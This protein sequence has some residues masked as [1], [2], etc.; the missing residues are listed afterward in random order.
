MSNGELKTGLWERSGRL[1][2]MASRVAGQELRHG[3]R[4]RL[5]A[6]AEARLRDEVT[7]RVAQAR[8]LT[9]SLGELKGAAMK[10]GQLLSIDAG[11]LLPDE[12]SAVLAKL[13]RHADPVPFQVIADVLLDE[14]G[15]ARLARL[16][17][18]ETIPAAAA[19]IGQV[20][21]ARVEGRPVAV[22]VQYP[23]IADTIDSDMRLLEKLADSWLVLTRSRIEIEETFEEMRSILHLEAD[24]EAEL[25]HL[26][27]FHA[28]L[29]DDD[30]FVVPTPYPE[31]STARVLTMSW[32]EG[33]PLG[34]WIAR[35]PG[36]DQRHRLA[37]SVLEL[38]CSEFFRWGLVQTDP[39]HGNF[40][41]RDD[42]RIVLLDFGATLSYDEGF[43]ETYVA[44]LRRLARGDV[45]RTIDTGIAFGIL[46]PR[47]PE[48][49]RQLFAEMLFSA[50]EPFRADLQPF[51]FRD[52]VYAAR[53]RDV[54]IRFTRS[55]RYS[56]PPRKLLFLH[57]K[58][59][60]IFQL[61]RRL[62]VTLDL[63]PYWGRM[64]GI[65][66]SSQAA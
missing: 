51:R 63:R 62:D 11:D 20:H 18:L 34:D 48:E 43:R 28:H 65:S 41:V 49:A 40:L 35:G 55:L 5:A 24:Y 19:S 53:S 16:E 59:G 13:Q 12:A 10:A 7:T 60:G 23:G 66:P 54:A 37:S 30:R 22:K 26:Q 1:L 3:L 38:Y 27:A 44:L 6:T 45:E 47:E 31:L 9:Q 46:D 36:P 39:N 14:L 4:K 2:G 32:E 15:P 52:E 42:G 50:V 29:R 33:T 25:R 61:L 8:I 64:V 57:R 17:G 58:L 21:R 56:P